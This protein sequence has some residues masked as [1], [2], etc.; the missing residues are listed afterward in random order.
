VR[1][2]LDENLPI[3]LAGDLRNLGHSADTVSD[4]GLCGAPDSEIVEAANVAR[5]VLL[6]LDKGIANLQ[7]Y[8]TAQHAGVVLFRPDT[9]GRR[10]V[11]VFVRGRLERI[12]E[13]DLTG[14][15]TLSDHIA[16]VQIARIQRQD[17]PGIRY[18]LLMAQCGEWIDTRGP[19]CRGKTG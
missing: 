10:A 19:G 1:F 2:K 4:E 17:Q 15:L 8:P 11:T 14:R 6:T 5:R 3:D 7:H 16:S 18:L 13:M 9:L 12:L